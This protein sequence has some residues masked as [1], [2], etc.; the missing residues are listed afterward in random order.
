MDGVPVSFAAGAVKH[1]CLSRAR[2]I[3]RSNSEK[4]DGRTQL[5]AFLGR[6][7]LDE[8]VRVV[9]EREHV[10]RKWRARLVKAFK[11]FVEVYGGGAAASEGPGTNGERKGSRATGARWGTHSRSIALNAA[12]NRRMSLPD[13][14]GRG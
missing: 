1:T 10:V 7:A 2:S 3:G 8:G 5:L 6:D 4:P 12:R 9:E 13:T 11:E 14:A